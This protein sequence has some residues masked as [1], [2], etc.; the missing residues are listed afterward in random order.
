MK[1]LKQGTPQQPQPGQKPF[2]VGKK[3][4]CI[5]CKCEVELEEGDDALLDRYVDEPE[6]Y[7][8]GWIYCPNC[9]ET[10]SLQ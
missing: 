4:E 2:W 9:H 8:F 1:I 6:D 3:L 5:E 7:S 10:I